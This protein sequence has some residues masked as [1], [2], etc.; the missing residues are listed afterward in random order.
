MLLLRRVAVARV[1][2]DSVS[3]GTRLLSRAP[4]ISRKTTSNQ[5]GSCWNWWPKWFA[6]NRTSTRF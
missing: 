1:A 3:R 6:E 5:C 4:D 2:P